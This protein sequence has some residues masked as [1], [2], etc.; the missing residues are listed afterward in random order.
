MTGKDPVMTRCVHYRNKSIIC[1]RRQVTGRWRTIR[2]SEN[3]NN[4]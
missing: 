1:T 2:R 3:D 4:I